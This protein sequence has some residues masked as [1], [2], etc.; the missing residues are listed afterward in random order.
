[1][2]N[3]TV[4]LLLGV[5]F[6]FAVVGVIIGFILL[7]KS[8]TPALSLSLPTQTY[9]NEEKWDVIKDQNGRVKTVVVHREATQR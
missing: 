9:N 3:D 8:S 7:T 5:T 1:M 2:D 6:G 4:T